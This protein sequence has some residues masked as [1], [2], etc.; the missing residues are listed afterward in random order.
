MYWRMVG[1]TSEIDFE[2]RMFDFGFLFV[3]SSFALFLPCNATYHSIKT[4]A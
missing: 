1:E 3:G 4:P 2:F